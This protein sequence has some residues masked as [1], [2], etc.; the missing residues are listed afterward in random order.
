MPAGFSFSFLQGRI[1]TVQHSS[2][3]LW[4]CKIIQGCIKKIHT[5]EN[6]DYFTSV[7]KLGWLIAVTVCKTYNTVHYY[8]NVML[9][10]FVKL[11]TKLGKIAGINSIIDDRRRQ[12]RLSSKII[13]KF[14]F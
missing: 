5:K 13:L 9:K 12:Q 1:Y 3:A 8:S 6:R 4:V 7:S 11:S 2:G 14:S 10:Y